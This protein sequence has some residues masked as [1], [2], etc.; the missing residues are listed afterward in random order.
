VSEGKIK[1][2]IDTQIFLRAGINRKS[3]PGRLVFELRDLYELK[4][5]TEILA[6]ITDVLNRP[7]IRKKFKTLTDNVVNELITLISSAEVVTLTETPAVSRDSKDDIF[8]ACAKASGA[9]YIVSEDK[10]LLV[11]HP[12]DGIQ[13]INALDFLRVLQPPPTE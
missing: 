9:Q 1:A 12:Y 8:L 5:A 13:I 10:D 3:L 7:E 11:L 6:E 4:V 2:V